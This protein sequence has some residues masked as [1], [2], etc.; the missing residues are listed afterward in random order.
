VTKTLIDIDTDLLTQC[1]CLLGTTTKK[2]TVNAALAEIVRLAAVRELSRM[3][4]DGIYDG[5]LSTPD[6][7]RAW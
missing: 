3:G 7:T 6:G 4:H 1:R 2:A 5:L